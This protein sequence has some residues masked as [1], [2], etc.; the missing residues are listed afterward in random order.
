MDEA[1][2]GEFLILRNPDETVDGVVIEPD[3]EAAVTGT[4]C[5]FQAENVETG[6]EHAAHPGL[7]VIRIGLVETSQKRTGSSRLSRNRADSAII[8][9][10][11]TNEQYERRYAA[12]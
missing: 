4:S 2:V 1:M 3:T 10:H 6:R 12:G 9:K 8:T 11:D 5:H 7:P